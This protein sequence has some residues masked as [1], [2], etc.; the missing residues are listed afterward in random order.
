LGSEGLTVI[1]GLARGIDSVAL[2]AAIKAEAPVIGVLG[3][4][5]DL[6]YPQ[7]NRKLF[8]EVQRLGACVSEFPPGAKPLKHHF[9]WRNRL[10]SGWGLGLLVV[11]AT[12]LSG[13][14]VTVRWALNQ[15]KDIFAIPGPVTHESSRGCHQMIREGATLVERPEEILDY[16]QPIL[17]QELKRHLQ[18]KLDK[19]EVAS[20][21]L[22]GL[23]TVSQTLEELMEKTE[24]S[25]P[26]LSTKLMRLVAMGKARRMPGGRYMLK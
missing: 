7:E 5:I 1:S 10:I 11:E 12:L 9:P 17:E 2:D 21:D 14:L 13:T 3:T 22:C 20:E 16:Y 15:G 19:V 25:Q 8:E 18:E 26:E 24:M 4:G 23:G 6:I